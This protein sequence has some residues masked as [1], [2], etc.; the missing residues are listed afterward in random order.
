MFEMVTP[1][2][3]ISNNYNSVLTL[4]YFSHTIVVQPKEEFIALHGCRDL[5]TMKELAPEPVAKENGWRVVNR[6][7]LTSIEEIVA[8]AGKL[9]PVQAGQSREK[10]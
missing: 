10:Y 6:I 4:I 8:A 1:A 3:V 7:P 9:N 2:Y 5:T